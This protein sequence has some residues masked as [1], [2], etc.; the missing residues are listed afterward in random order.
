MSEERVLGR[1][2]AFHNHPHF[3]QFPVRREELSPNFLLC[4]HLI[5]DLAR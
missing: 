2:E 3:A 5:L 4:R 1:Y